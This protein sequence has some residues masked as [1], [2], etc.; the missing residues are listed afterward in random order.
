MIQRVSNR[1]PGRGGGASANELFPS[2]GWRLLLPDPGPKHVVALGDGP[3]AA[4]ARRLW[5][6]STSAPVDDRPID[7]VV[8]D[9][10]DPATLAA[11]AGLLDPTTVA[12][13]QFDW[14]RHRPYGHLRT[15]LHRAG[16]APTTLYSISPGR[17]RWAATWWI[18]V[19]DIEAA[20]FVAGRLTA[21]RSR[22]ARPIDRIRGALLAHWQ[23]NPGLVARVPWLLHPSR[24]Q[25]LGI[26][27][28]GPG[29]HRAEKRTEASSTT[30]MKIGGS[31]TDQPIL[32]TF[33]PR[34]E[35][36]PQPCAEVDGPDVVFKVPTLAEEIESSRC[37][38]EML[39]TLAALDPPVAQIPRP[40][41]ARHYRRA[42]LQA[43]GQTYAP[44]RPMAVVATPDL[45]P[46]HA[47]AV[48]DWVLEL[49]ARTA[50]AADPERKLASLDHTMAELA[51]SLRALPDAQDLSRRLAAAVR[52][53]DRSLSVHRHNDLGPWNV[54]VTATGTITVIDWADATDDGIPACDLIHFLAHLAFCAYD[55]YGPVR[56]DRL[57]ADLVDPGTPLGQ[58][59][60]R[61]TADH[62]VRL[63][64]SPDQ[65]PDLRLITWALD[66]LRRPP[67]QRTSGLYLDLL[68]A[69]VRR[70][71]SQP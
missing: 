46:A 65:I 12:Y 40:V 21:S 56:R 44:G 63:G 16:L 51:Q 32:F 48:G 53:I 68:R 60:W 3:I 39:T 55:G 37:E 9:S 64:M 70:T 17:H 4:T 29:I 11:V 58:V 15:R 52:G 8:A 25:Q 57:I 20:Q 61:A 22:S 10:P 24:N 69:Q 66:L 43:F 7:L 18:P 38:A 36:Q 33:G 30:I 13:L 34:S 14:P 31:S 45:L 62:V 28:G 1:W 50:Q 71:T 59:V 42:G 19:N 5:P 27:I 67:E 23:R 49:A 35:A 41:D 6:E 2:E 54:Q 26:V 47:A